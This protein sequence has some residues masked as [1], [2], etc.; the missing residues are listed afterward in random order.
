[1]EE[2]GPDNCDESLRQQEVRAVREPYHCLLPVTLTAKLRQ[3]HSITTL[4]LLDSGNCW[5]TAISPAMAEALGVTREDLRPLDNPVKL[6]T[7]DETKTLNVWGEMPVNVTF[8]VN[9]S[10]KRFK[11]KPIVIEG[12]ASGLNIGGPL[13][14]ALGWS[15]NPARGTVTDARGHALK[16]CASRAEQRTGVQGVRVAE[17]SPQEDQERESD[18]AARVL[19]QEAT[20]VP[21][22]ST[23][24]LRVRLDTKTKGWRGAAKEAQILGSVKFMEATDLHPGRNAVVKFDKD[25][26]AWAAVHNSRRKAIAIPADMEYGIAELCV[27]PPRPGEDPSDA[28]KKLKQEM[29]DPAFQKYTPDQQRE[30]LVRCFRLDQ[31]PFLQDEKEL[32]KAAEFLRQYWDKFAWT[33]DFGV[34]SLLEHK[35]EL[36]EGTKPVK[37]RY[38]PI[39]RGLEESCRNQ[40]KEW[41]RQGVI[42]RSNSPWSSNLLAVKKKSGEIRWCK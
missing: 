38:R 6:C 27:V 10:K 41:L 30:F 36:E 37:C 34:T 11:L 5:R 9:E 18:N 32:W 13:L 26:V 33:G 19:C 2:V 40:I 12:L 7:A 1:M 28:K 22:N 4:A 29:K 23:K 15:L 39:A 24:L 20:I 25:G 21:G 14:A 42:E 17:L 16:L 31:S 3:L 8:C 35:I